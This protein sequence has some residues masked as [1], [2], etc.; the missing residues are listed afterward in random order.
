VLFGEGI[1][2]PMGGK[3]SCLQ[4]T[5]HLVYLFSGRVSYLIFSAVPL[6]ERVPPVQESPRTVQMA[7]DQQ[8]APD[9]R[10]RSGWQLQR[11]VNRGAPGR[12]RAGGSGPLGGGDGRGRGPTPA[13][14]PCRKDGYART[15]GGGGLTRAGKMRLTYGQFLRVKRGGQVS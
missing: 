3:W 5:L 8:P 10:C 7:T 1:L 13:P 11:G 14:R 9:P 2:F 12:C 15:Q 4:N 6:G